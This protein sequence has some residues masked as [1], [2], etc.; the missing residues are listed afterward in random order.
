M[1][2]I[3]KILLTL[4]LSLVCI[5]FP[6]AAIKENI[7]E[8]NKDTYIIG[9]SKFNN[10][11][12]ISASDTSKSEA[13]YAYLLS[14]LGKDIDN[15]EINTYYYS[16]LTN[17]WFKISNN[18]EFILLNQTDISKLE[19]N[20]EIFYVNNIEK[21]IEFP[22]EN[23]VLEGSITDPKVKFENNKFVIP[24]TSIGFGFTS[25]GAQIS[26]DLKKN[27]NDEYDFGNYYIP[28]IVK[29]YD[30]NN[31]LLTILSTNSEGKI[32]TGLLLSYTKEGYKVAYA[33]KNNN[34]IDLN[35][36][37]VTNNDLELHQVWLPIGSIEN[38]ETNTFNKDTLTLNYKGVLNRDRNGY[39]IFYTLVAPFGFD[40]SDTKVEGESSVWTVGEKT[41]A[42]IK[43]YVATKDDTTIIVNW[44]GKNTT[45]SYNYYKSK[46]NNVNYYNY[47]GKTLL[48]TETVTEGELLKASITVPPRNGYLYKGLTTVANKKEL[49][50]LN[51]PVTSDLNLYTYYVK[52]PTI[53]YDNKAIGNSPIEFTKD[54]EVI[55]TL[56]L[57]HFDF[58]G[59]TITVSAK[60]QNTEIDENNY[61]LVNVDGN[62]VDFSKGITLS[63][64][65]NSFT[66]LE[67]KVKKSDNISTPIEFTTKYNEE[68]ISTVYQSLGLVNAEDR[69]LE[70]D[71][72]NSK[73]SLLRIYNPNKISGTIIIGNVTIIKEDETSYIANAA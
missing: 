30:E 35:T 18:Q 72:A 67:I 65:E 59:K 71:G 20:L 49:F 16:D 43:K 39:Y 66:N 7:N 45:G 8:I 32:E 48:S 51:T 11:F 4:V 46:S 13:D 70:F 26:V 44:D 12:I 22:Y 47:N 29:V 3:N 9:I 55:D 36:L 52:T 54:E 56:K 5:S 15:I 17:E 33:D 19:N 63:L 6:K 68:I 2:N 62:W 37:I 42:I 21:I 23:E 38:S 41:T 53:I 40:A 10:E 60:F 27:N 28:N 64:S 69:V 61:I 24:A 31:N 25:N 1:R 14:L 73:A 58:A 34:I 50:D 57:K